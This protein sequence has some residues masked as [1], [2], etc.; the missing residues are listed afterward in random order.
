[1][2]SWRKGRQKQRR[3]PAGIETHPPCNTT[4]TAIRQKQRR[5]PAG[6]ETDMTTRQFSVN[7]VCQNQR[8]SPAG[9]ETELPWPGGH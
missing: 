3:S 5:S 4:T 2:L 7:A 6:I 8:R 1:M 9:I